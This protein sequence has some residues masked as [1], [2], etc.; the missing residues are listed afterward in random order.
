MSS[1]GESPLSPTV[2]DINGILLSELATTPTVEQ[3]L[4]WSGVAHR[5]N[6][7]ISIE[8]GAVSLLHFS[9]PGSRSLL[10]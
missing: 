7:D 10:W 9:A 8:N 3:S 5:Q 4:T 6:N 1:N 2:N